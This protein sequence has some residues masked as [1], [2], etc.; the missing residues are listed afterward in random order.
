MGNFDLPAWSGIIQKGNSSVIA[1]ANNVMSL[2][3]EV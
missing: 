3:D 1:S 2:Q